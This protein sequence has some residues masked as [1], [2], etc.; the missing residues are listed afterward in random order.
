MKAN[1]PNW[2]AKSAKQ[3]LEIDFKACLAAS[4]GSADAASAGP[5]RA[6]YEQIDKETQREEAMTIL[7]M[8]EAADVS[9]AGFYRRHEPTTQDR[10]IVL[11]DQIQK[12]ALEFPCYGRRRI[13]AE[14]R[15][16]GW[17][18]NHRRVH[19]IMPKTIYCACGGRSLW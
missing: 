2:S 7:H 6:I 4:R 10:D 14:L 19:R 11:R 13:V 5:N 9:R 1:L 3:T 8:C 18:V 12:I 15:R 17:K 16:R